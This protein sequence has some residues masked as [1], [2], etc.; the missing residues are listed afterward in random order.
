MLISI[1]MLMFLLF[2]DQIQWRQKSRGGYC[3]RGRPC[4]LPCGKKPGNS[5][6][7][8]APIHHIRSEFLERNLC[9]A[10]CQIIFAMIIISK[11]ICFSSLLQIL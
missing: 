6:E 3:R 7:K 4:P 2:L 8:L 9:E 1:V 5:S 10:L 11:M